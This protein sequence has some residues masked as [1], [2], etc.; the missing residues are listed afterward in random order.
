MP[1]NLG[2]I[3][4]VTLLVLLFAFRVSAPSRESL[5]ILDSRPIK[6]YKQLIHAIGM[7]ETRSDTLAYN[8]IEEAVGFFQIRPIRLEDYNKRTGSNYTMKDMF[9]YE[10]SE[11][12]FL[13]FAEQIGPY[14]FEK[15][16]KKWN[17]S[18]HMTINYWNR[19]KRYL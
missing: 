18:G 4:F 7:V 6:P 19:I 13:Y 16:A 1:G 15:I 9:N 11:K 2:K 17:G 8:P 14:D 5:I 12:I 3:V 10:I